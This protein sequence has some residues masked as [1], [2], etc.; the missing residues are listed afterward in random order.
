MSRIGTETG[1]RTVGVGDVTEIADS[2][3][4]KI[5]V[6]RV[7]PFLLTSHVL[8]F[9]GA[10]ALASWFLARAFRTGWV[11]WPLAACAASIGVFRCGNG[12]RSLSWP[13]WYHS[14]LSIWWLKSGGSKLFLRVF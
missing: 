10:H 1:I 5:S 3:K 8:R 11:F 12:H 6:L 2:G 13:L 9:S 14:G 7:R 4:Q